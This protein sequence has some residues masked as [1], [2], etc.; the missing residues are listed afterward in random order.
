[1]NFNIRVKTKSGAEGFGLA[2]SYTDISPI[3]NVVKS[4]YSMKSLVWTRL[5][6]TCLREIIR[7]YI[8]RITSENGWGRSLSG[9]PQPLTS[10][11]GMFQGINETYRYIRYLAAT[12]ME[13]LLCYL[14]LLSR[15]KGQLGTTRKKSKCLLSKD[16]EVLKERIGGLSLSEYCQNGGVRDV[17]NEEENNLMVDVNRA[18]DTKPPLER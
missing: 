6:L 18:W 11:V 1:M 16:T 14:C 5:H 2:T 12:A 9:Y 17:I 7:L 10:L 13:S 4:G 8:Q 3:V 15:R